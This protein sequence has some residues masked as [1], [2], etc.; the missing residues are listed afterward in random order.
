MA[1]TLTF[2]KVKIYRHF[3]RNLFYRKIVSFCLHVKTNSNFF[4]EAK[5]D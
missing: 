2:K 3:A 5:K 4:Q 1:L